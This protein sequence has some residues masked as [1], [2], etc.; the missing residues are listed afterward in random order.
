MSR[1]TLY[2]RIVFPLALRHASRRNEFILMIKSTALASVITLT[3]VAAAI[4]RFINFVVTRLIRLA[5]YLSA[6]LRPPRAAAA[7]GR[8]G[9]L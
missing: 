1:F 4:H 9:A 6:E 8:G 5:E 3:I 2:Y 7:T